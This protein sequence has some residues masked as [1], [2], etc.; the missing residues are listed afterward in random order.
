MLYSMVCRAW[1]LRLSNACIE[2]GCRCFV[3]PEDG[4]QRANVYSVSEAGIEYMS[5]CWLHQ[6]QL[7]ASCVTCSATCTHMCTVHAL[8]M[9]PSRASFLRHAH[10]LDPE[11]RPC[12]GPTCAA[13]AHFQMP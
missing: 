1:L 6:Q 4:V 13:A 10:T 5:P 2:K 12:S 7:Q 3:Q 11:H 9:K 8:Q